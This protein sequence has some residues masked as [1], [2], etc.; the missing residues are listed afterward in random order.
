M[1]VNKERVGLNVLL[2]LFHHMH[3]DRN[4][5]LPDIVCFA[6]LA[7]FAFAA[8]FFFEDEGILP[9]EIIFPISLLYFK[10]TIAPMQ[11]FY[12]ID[13]MLLT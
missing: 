10:H 9:R 13:V 12:G 1:R 3:H 2:P 7:P 5:F 6:A 4:Y 8:S 11:H